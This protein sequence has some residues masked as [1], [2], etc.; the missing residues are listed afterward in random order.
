MSESRNSGGPAPPCPEPPCPE[1][2][3][4][5]RLLSNCARTLVAAHGEEAPDIARQ[6]A[7][8]ACLDGDG[9]GARIWQSVA[10]LAEEMLRREP[11]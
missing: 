9:E 8:A 6:R 4:E 3:C 2:P 7:D 11:V 10:A 5:P 1:P